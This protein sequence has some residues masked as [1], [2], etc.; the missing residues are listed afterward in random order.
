MNIL[1]IGDIVG[2]P[3]RFVVADNLNRLKQEY[4]IS[5]V[6]ANGE[7]SAHGSGITQKVADELFNLGINV[8]TMG[9]HTWAKKEIVDILAKENR[10]VRPAN[11]PAG[12][13]GKGSTIFS[14]NGVRIGVINLMGRVNMEPLESPFIVG[15]N[16]I[17]KLRKETDL[18]MV[19]FHA[20]TTSEKIALGWYFDGR[21][22]AV[23][24]THTHVQTADNRVLDKGTGYMTDL[25]M[26]G[27]VDSVLGV[28]KEIIIDK[29]VKQLPN[30]FEF[31]EKGQIQLNGAV[32]DI[33]ENNGKCRKVNRISLSIYE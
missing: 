28:K 15:D 25:G 33:D 32:F 8:L 21:A 4:N 30:K 26:T 18:I 5:A 14:V 10:I 19:D 27:C 24:G 22:T 2:R 1:A 11:Y 20:E 29:F 23:W 12:T 31:A 16:E 13:P 9:N 6:I 3:G 7:N 17:D